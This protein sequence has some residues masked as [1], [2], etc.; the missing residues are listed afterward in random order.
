MKRLKM[1]NGERTVRAWGRSTHE[2]GGIRDSRRVTGKTS[3]I[4][5][6]T[7]SVFVSRDFLK[8]VLQMNAFY[9]P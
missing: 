7:A 4:W 1:N 5:T 2:E 8:C 9:A 6:M 3:G